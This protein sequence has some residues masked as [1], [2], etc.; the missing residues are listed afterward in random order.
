VGPVKPEAKRLID[1]AALAFRNGVA[2]VRPGA[3]ACDIGRAVHRTVAGAGFSVVEGLS[4][5]GIGRTIHEWP[6]IPNYDDADCQDRLTEGMVFTIEPLIA[7]GGPRTVTLRDGWT[8]RTRDR[9]LAAHHEHTV[10]VT[11]CGAR[12]LTA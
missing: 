8:I 10:M 11:A 5:H 1:C 6:T 3:R 2:Q 7:M 12:I 4:G 9:S